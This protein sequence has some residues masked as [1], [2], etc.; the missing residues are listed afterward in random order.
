MLDKCIVC[1]KE[2]ECVMVEDL[3]HFCRECAPVALL[4]EIWKDV[5]KIRRAL[6]GELSR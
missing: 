5:R 2:T 3:G 1:G 6:R 4:A